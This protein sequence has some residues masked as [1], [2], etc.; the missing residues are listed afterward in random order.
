MKINEGTGIITTFMNVE[1]HGIFR[2]EGTLYMRISGEQYCNALCLETDKLEKCYGGEEVFHYPDAEIC[3]DGGSYPHTNHEDF[4]EF[5]DNLADE[6]MD[7]ATGPRDGSHKM[8]SMKLMLGHEFGK[9]VDVKG[10]K[11]PNNSYTNKP[12]EMAK[13]E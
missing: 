8:D 3:L 1:H 6:I 4:V 7:I 10:V 9:F 13:N 5:I 12:K 11:Y 2:K